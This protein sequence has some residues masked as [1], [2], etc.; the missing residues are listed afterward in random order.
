MNLPKLKSLSRNNSDKNKQK[1]ASSNSNSSGGS[2]NFASG[3]HRHSLKKPTELGII[4]EES[5]I[6]PARLLQPDPEMYSNNY[7]SDSSGANNLYKYSGGLQSG[8]NQTYLSSQYSER[9]YFPGTLNSH[10]GMNM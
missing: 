8:M 6:E 4:H 1:Y 9:S 7:I 5:N 3:E 10:E 2:A